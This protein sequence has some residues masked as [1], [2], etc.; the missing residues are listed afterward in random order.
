[1]AT[2]AVLPAAHPRAEP[3]NVASAP[4]RAPAP[5]PAPV[6]TP[7]PPAIY[8]ASATPPIVHGGQALV[9]DVRTTPDVV[10]VSARTT[11]IVLPLQHLG[12]GHFGLTFS[13]PQGVPGFFHGTYRMDVSAVTSAGATLHRDVAV[14]FQ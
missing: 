12:P 6:S 13:V 8:S 11:M 7:P 14:T 3:A 4:A 2:T 1:M 10:S 9:W 5:S